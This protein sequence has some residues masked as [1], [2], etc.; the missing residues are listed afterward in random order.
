MVKR[1]SKTLF[2]RTLD[3]VSVPARPVSV[4]ADFR[5]ALAAG[6][7]AAAALTVAGVWG[8]VHGRAVHQRVIAVVGAIAFLV[9]SVVAIRSTASEVY[10]VVSARTGPSHADVLRWLIT[11]AGYAVVVLTAFGLLAVPVQHL[12]LGGALTGVIVGIAAQQALGNIFAGIVLLL[13][14][15]FNVGDSIRVK[16]GSLGGELL[17]TVAGMGLTYVTLDTADGPLSLP[18][19]TMLAAGIGPAVL[20]ADDADSPPVDESAPAEPAVAG[21]APTVPPAGG[22]GSA[23][24]GGAAAVGAV[25]GQSD[26]ADQSRAWVPADDG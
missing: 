13:A 20:P 23:A 12:V 21:G 5:M 26:G 7:A 9:F 22:T 2:H 24:S 11:L 10:R 19:S 3:R 17:G 18:N 15:P 14:R 8:D 25:A 1:F 4:S 16:S 6:V